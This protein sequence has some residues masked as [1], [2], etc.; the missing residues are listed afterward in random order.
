MLIDISP[1]PGQNNKKIR[2]T[3]S[4]EGSAAASRRPSQRQQEKAPE[5]RTP[6]AVVDEAAG[7]APDAEVEEDDAGPIADANVGASM[8]TGGDGRFHEDI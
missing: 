6:R 4:P 8:S 3:P 2:A 5:G 1:A 7:T